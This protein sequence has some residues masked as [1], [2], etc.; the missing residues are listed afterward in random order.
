MVG[1][2]IAGSSEWQR[3][4]T[5]SSRKSQEIAKSADGSPRRRETS[6]AMGNGISPPDPCAPSLAPFYGTSLACYIRRSHFGAQHDNFLALY[7][8]QRC[9]GRFF[10]ESANACSSQSTLD[11][12]YEHS[13]GRCDGRRYGSR[14]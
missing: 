6:A 13:A 11:R 4:A 7:R 9:N 14:I 10:D 3:I 5:G 12:H 2:A 1:D 8:N